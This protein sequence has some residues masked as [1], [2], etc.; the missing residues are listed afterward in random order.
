MRSAGMI[1]LA[2]ELCLV[3]G[4][5]YCKNSNNDGQNLLRYNVTLG[6]ATCC[7][8]QVTPLITNLPRRADSNVCHYF[9][10]C[11]TIAIACPGYRLRFGILPQPRSCCVPSKSNEAK[12]V[13]SLICKQPANEH[14]FSSR[15]DV[16][17]HAS[18]LRLPVSRTRIRPR[19]QT[20]NP[21]Q[22]SRLFRTLLKRGVSF[23]GQ[24]PC[25]SQDAT[26]FLETCLTAACST[27]C[28]GA[29]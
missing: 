27:K 7:T 29:A 20:Q 17:S 4:D 1:S 21:T 25:S 13:I 11:G 28:R 26:S 18:L 10:V 2:R 3:P 23:T 22:K 15:E 12:Q 16:G 8:A 19:Q 9:V 5:H 6:L 24:T 14:R